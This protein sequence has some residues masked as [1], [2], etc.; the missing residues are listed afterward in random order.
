MTTLEEILSNLEE[1]RPDPI[2]D[3][4]I[5]LVESITD[6]LNGNNGAEEE[7]KKLRDDVKR[8]SAEK[9]KL[10]NDWKERYLERFRGG[11]SVS[12]FG[13]E[14][15]KDLEEPETETLKSREEVAEEWQ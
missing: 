12:D 13:R 9:E 10:D 6:S 11:D 4:Y 14:E 1:F 7:L 2:S 15:A 3:S 5:S 8:L